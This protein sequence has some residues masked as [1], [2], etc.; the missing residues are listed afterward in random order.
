MQIMGELQTNKAKFLFKKTGF[1]PD[2]TSIIYT[3]IITNNVILYFYCKL[4]VLHLFKR[5]RNGTSRGKGAILRIF[6]LNAGIF[7]RF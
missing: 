5:S 6:L 2:Y 7:M 4:F 1:L 3:T